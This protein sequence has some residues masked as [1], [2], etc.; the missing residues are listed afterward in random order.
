MP[1]SKT[2]AFDRHVYAVQRYVSLTAPRYAG[3]FRPGLAVHPICSFGDPAQARIVT[4][5]VNPSDREFVSA[6]GWPDM[7][8]DH[9]TLAER[10]RNYFTKPHKWFTPWT[11]GLEY[12]KAGYLDGS[13]VHIDLSPR[14]T[15]PVFD[16]KF[17]REQD[18]FLDMVQ[19]DLW[20]FF[21]MLELCT[22]AQL[23]ILA[24]SVTGKFYINEF[25][26]RFAPEYGYSLDGAFNRLEH[27]GRG[28]T[29]SHELSGGGRKL[30]VFF[31]SSSPSDKQET[32]LPKRMKEFAK[33]LKT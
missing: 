30:N 19:R 6:R 5:G 25:V 33:Q 16:F 26:Q 11:E 3:L 4:V 8:M 2:S 18:L 12:L 21:G 23:I 31:C 28:K 22:K 29:A 24:G 1:T 10:Y 7:Q 13:A 9:T 17:A 15:R 27:P 20:A 32:L 14:A